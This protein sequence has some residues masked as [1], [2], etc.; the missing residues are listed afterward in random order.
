M[1]Q[2]QDLPQRQL[3][4]IFLM[5]KPLILL[6]C[7][8]ALLGCNGSQAPSA[9]GSSAV[10][11]FLSESNKPAVLKFYA[12]WCSS[13]KQY[14]PAFEQVKTTL[15]DK[16][17]FYE[18]DVDESQY[19]ALVKELKISRIPETVFVSKDRT[20]L[21]KRLGPMSVSTLSKL[22]NSTLTQ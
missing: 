2:D 8:F 6:V 9:G 20:N 13:C 21:S 12:E 4:I 16:A 3:V 18:I 10:N 7:F 11:D 22:V 19:R 1:R 5:S 14:A 15:S 17:D